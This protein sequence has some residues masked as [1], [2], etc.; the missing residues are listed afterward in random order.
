MKSVFTINASI[1]HLEETY[2]VSFL[3]LISFL[4]DKFNE[5]DLYIGNEFEI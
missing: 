1:E 5:I 3:E 4:E 2:V